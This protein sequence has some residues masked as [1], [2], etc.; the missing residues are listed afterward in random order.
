MHFVKRIVNK[1]TRFVSQEIHS[2][3]DGTYLY[4]PARF[5]WHFH[6]MLKWYL[7]K[8][9]E[10]LNGRILDNKL[11]QQYHFEFVPI[12]SHSVV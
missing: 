5:E 8:A 1:L 11:S 12:D 9:F 10:L 2:R 7:K 3:L 4:P 6:P